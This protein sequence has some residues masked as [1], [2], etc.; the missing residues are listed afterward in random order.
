MRVEVVADSTMASIGVARHDHDRR[1]S[2]KSFSRAVAHPRS[3]CSRAAGAGL[4]MDPKAMLR[5]ALSGP[6]AEELQFSAYDPMGKPRA[7]LTVDGTLFGGEGQIL[8]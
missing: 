7:S 2:R 5:G 3:P 1:K 4:G 8:A 6:A